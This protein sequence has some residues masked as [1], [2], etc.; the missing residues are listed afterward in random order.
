MKKGLGPIKPK[1]FLDTKKQMIGRGQ[2][3]IHKESSKSSSMSDISSQSIPA[4]CLYEMTVEEM[5]LFHDALIVHLN[6]LLEKHGLSLIPATFKNKYYSQL[7]KLSHQNHWWSWLQFRKFKH[8]AV[9]NSSLI[10]ICS[11]ASIIPQG[12]SPFYKIPI[13]IHRFVNHLTL[14]A[15]SVQGIFRVSGNT[16]RIGGLLDIYDDQTDYGNNY[17]FQHHTVYDVADA[18]KKFL[19]SL[20]EPLFTHMLHD[21]FLDCLQIHNEKDQIHALQQL[22]L[23]LPREHS[24]ALLYILEFLVLVASKSSENQMDL[25]NL[26]TIF[27]PNLM[28]S[29][30]ESHAITDYPKTIK[31]ISILLHNSSEFKLYDYPAYE[32]LE[33]YK[34][35]LPELEKKKS[36]SRPR[37]VTMGVATRY[38][39]GETNSIPTS[40]TPSQL[41][42]PS[43]ASPLRSST[44]EQSTPRVVDSPSLLV[45][46]DF[47]STRVDTDDLGTSHISVQDRLSAVIPNRLSFKPFRS[48]SSTSPSRT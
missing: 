12:R 46:T 32:F 37:A 40:K 18:L 26:A 27:A 45:M 34:G 43:N 16:K 23:F 6:K 38:S 25:T 2:L 33:G 42:V 1:S 35:K 11:F 21:K 22:I 48:R 19:R 17:D 41:F 9:S 31:L 44:V 13:I 4:H 10:D 8:T 3:T 5:L 28:S 39:V 29:S 7:F 14:N 47:P 20:P 24:L 36:V 30:D 15:L